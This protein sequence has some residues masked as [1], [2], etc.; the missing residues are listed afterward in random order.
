MQQ[1]RETYRV[2]P[3]FNRMV[4]EDFV[5]NFVSQ[6]ALNFVRTKWNDEKLAFHRFGDLNIVDVAAVFE[7]H[8]AQA[9]NHSGD[10]GFEH[11]FTLQLLRIKRH[12]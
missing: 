4:R 6:R 8:L 2:F 11:L 10:S 3:E 12:L 9:S 5:V 1:V 7:K